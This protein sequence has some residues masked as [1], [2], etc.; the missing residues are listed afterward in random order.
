MLGTS[1]DFF[2]LRFKEEFPEKRL[3]I[4]LLE[5]CLHC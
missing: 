1:E 5:S 3:R 4:W 2:R